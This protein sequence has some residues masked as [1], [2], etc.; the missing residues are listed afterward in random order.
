VRRYLLDTGPLAAYLLNRTAATRI[1]TPWTRQHEA[2]TSILVY[3]EIMEYLKGKPDFANRR[4]Q[5]NTLLRAVY[6]VSLTYATMERYADLRR[7]M[8]TPFGPG[9]IGDVD[10]LIAATALERNLTVVT[11]DGDFQRIPGLTVHRRACF[12]QTL[13]DFVSVLVRANIVQYRVE[14]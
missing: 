10:T 8:R 7:V 5:L 12:T 4:T 1:I 3:G 9:L 6:P 14:R 11:T 2:V 13:T